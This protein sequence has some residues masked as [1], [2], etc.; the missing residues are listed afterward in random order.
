LSLF[1]HRPQALNLHVEMRRREEEMRRKEECERSEERDK[2]DS[3]EREERERNLR[4]EMEL[5]R[6]RVGGE[7]GG[8]E[9]G[10]SPPPSKRP[11]PAE[12]ERREVHGITGLTLPRGVSLPGTNIKI[13]TRGE[14]PAGP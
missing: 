3:E 7:E 5:K 9:E 10:V 13:T 11:H 4:R 14:R 8:R 2:K 6:E 1:D 12:E